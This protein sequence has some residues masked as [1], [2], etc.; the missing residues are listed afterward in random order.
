MSIHPTLRYADARAAIAFLTTALGFRAGEVTTGDD[1]AVQHA[2]LAFGSPPGVV[3]I[4]QR[5]GGPGPW[6]TGRAVTYLVVDDPDARHDAAVAAG[7]QVVMGLTDQP[8]GSREFAVAD[9][10][11]NVWSVG[12]YRPAAP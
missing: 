4:G 5:S 7:A 10:E 9:S 12:T 6:D 3:L 8:Y 11:G 2:E 1:G